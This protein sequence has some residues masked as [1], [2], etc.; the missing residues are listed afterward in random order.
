[1]FLF[2]LEEMAYAY[3]CISPEDIDGLQVM[4]YEVLA[5]TEMWYRLRK[6]SANPQDMMR[7]NAMPPVVLGDLTGLERLVWAIFD[8]VLAAGASPELRPDEFW[9]WVVRGIFDKLIYV[10]R[11]PSDQCPA[12]AVGAKD[13]QGPSVWVEAPAMC[14]HHQGSEPAWSTNRGH[15]A[16]S[17]RSMVLA[18]PPEQVGYQR[19][20][21][22]KA[23]SDWDEGEDDQVMSLQVH[24][25]QSRDHKTYK[26]PCAKAQG[27]TALRLTLCF[28]SQHAS[29]ALGASS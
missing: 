18:I 25:W 4:T 27:I 6:R 16:P 24:V 12:M 23:Y 26:R 3:A 21:A 19:R 20:Q 29:E 15:P 10:G 13:L 7:G 1:M 5:M 2:L 11:N 28:T 8:G 17:V 14:S 22:A 9:E